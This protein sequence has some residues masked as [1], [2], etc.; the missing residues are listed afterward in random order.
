VIRE[1]TLACEFNCLS[2]G[3]ALQGVG[4]SSAAHNAV[5]LAGE[6]PVVGIDCLSVAFEG[7]ARISSSRWVCFVEKLSRSECGCLEPS[8]ARLAQGWAGRPCSMRR[9]RLTSTGTPAQVVDAPCLV[10][11]WANRK[12]SSRLTSLALC[13]G[14]GGSRRARPGHIELD[15]D[16]RAGKLGHGWKNRESY[17]ADGGSVVDWCGFLPH[18]HECSIVG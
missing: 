7:L 13:G 14:D 16:A 18:S 17:D 12:C 8:M 1:I 15:E 2:R 11:R 10:T 3:P 4:P 6:S 9:M 5:G